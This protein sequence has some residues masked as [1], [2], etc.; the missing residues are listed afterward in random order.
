MSRSG[1][2][3]ALVAFALACLSTVAWGLPTFGNKCGNCHG[4]AT[5]GALSIVNNNG[6]TT[7]GGTSYPVFNVTPGVPTALSLRV[8]GTGL[9]SG[10]V[11]AL[12]VD[13]NSQLGTTGSK[14]IFSYA[15][16]AGQWSKGGGTTS[17]YYTPNFFTY[18]GATTQSFTI[19]VDPNTPAGLYPLWGKI[20]GVA[21][22]YWG[23]TPFYVNVGHAPEPTMMAILGAGATALFLRGRAKRRQANARQ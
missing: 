10:D 17:W 5:S 13:A 4:S 20:G 22:G 7:V 15:G 8:T 6:T 11:F 2:L 18:G 12:A 21:G 9:S 3:V 14:L 1:R 23:Q 19:N 16:T